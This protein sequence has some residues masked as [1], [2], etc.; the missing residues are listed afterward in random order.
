MDQVI[1]NQQRNHIMDIKVS[2]AILYMFT[3]VS[4][5]MLL[6]GCNH[7]NKDLKTAHVGVLGNDPDA[8]ADD[9]APIIRAP[10]RLPYILAP[11]DEISINVLEDERLTQDI[12]LDSDGGFQFYYVG[13]IKAEGLTTLDLKKKLT[14]SLAEFYVEPHVAV[15]LKSEEQQFVNVIG[16][17]LKPGRI[18]L[19]RGMRILDAI[20]E[21]GGAHPD[22]DRQRVIL[23]RR[24]S[25]DKPPYVVA[26]F[27]DYKDAMLNPLGGAM[28]SN[29]P[30]QRG[31]TIYF[32]K[33]GK[34]QWESVFKF[35]SE[36]S[37]SISDVERSIILYPKVEDVFN[38]GEIQ[39]T[40]NIIVR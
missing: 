14:T 10:L 25:D 26:G 30:L 11:G 36:M 35:I 23:I 1:K 17:P 38:F 18:R 6:T 31:D 32:P 20:A 29:I 28:A 5:I 8:A 9:I 12:R 27:F 21:A 4:V 15:N 22:A 19:T 24:V 34:A 33:N 39:G 7:P 13:R 2:S 37:G 16:L 40:T 3:L